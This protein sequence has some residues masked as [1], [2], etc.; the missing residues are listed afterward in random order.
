MYILLFYFHLVQVIYY[1]HLTK[2]NLSIYFYSISQ[3]KFMINKES[4]D[5]GDFSV[6]IFVCCIMSFS[7]MFL[8]QDGTFQ[9]S[10][11]CTKKSILVAIHGAN[12]W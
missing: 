11:D 6:V 2:I 9:R 8:S 1:L 12:L 10:M 3:P 5:C 7:E 4:G